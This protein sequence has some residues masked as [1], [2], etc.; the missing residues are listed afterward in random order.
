[1][2]KKLPLNNFKW[3]DPNKY[4]SGFI[5]NY[6]DESDKGYLLEVDVHYPKHL[7]NAQSDQSFLPEK[8]KKYI[9]PLNMK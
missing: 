3:S 2:N 7:H 1:M 4:T 9:N 5:R 8:R 6:D